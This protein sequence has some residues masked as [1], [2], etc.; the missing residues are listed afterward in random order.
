M[1]SSKFV[2]MTFKEAL[3]VSGEVSSPMSLSRKQELAIVN[4]TGLPVFVVDWP[5]GSKPFYAKS[6]PCS[7]QVSVRGLLVCSEP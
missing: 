5:P 2:E 4:K 3:K 7:G 1:C 6:D